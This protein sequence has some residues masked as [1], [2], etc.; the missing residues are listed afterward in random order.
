MRNNQINESFSGISII[1]HLDKKSKSYLNLS[2]FQKR[3]SYQGNGAHTKSISK[4]NNPYAN[5]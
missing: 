5:L 2:V 4:L 1:K 3:A